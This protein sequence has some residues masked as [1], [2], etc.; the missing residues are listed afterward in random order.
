MVRYPHTMKVSTRAS[1]GCIP[2][3]QRKIKV[4][5]SPG[6]VVYTSSAHSMGLI[7]IYKQCDQAKPH[8]QMCVKRS[9]RCFSYREEA[10]LMFCDE[11]KT[12]VRKIGRISTVDQARSSSNLLTHTTS[13]NHRPDEVLLPAGTW[14]LIENPASLSPR[15]WTLQ[16]SPSF[17][18]HNWTSQIQ[19]SP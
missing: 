18:D 16:D 12:V 14:T 1:R 2:C 10:D 9:K 3:R 4:R 11:T 13:T 15:P 5:G 17:Q 19:N 8:C 7:A 6:F